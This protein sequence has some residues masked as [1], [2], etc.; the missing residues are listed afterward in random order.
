M[1][2]PSDKS[3]RKKSSGGPRRPGRPK[4]P[5]KREHTHPGG[6]G[7]LLGTQLARFSGM[8]GFS[9]LLTNVLHYGSIVVVAQMLGPGSLGAY[10]LLFFLTALVTQ[11]IHIALQAG[12]D[13]ADLRRLRRR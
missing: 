11:V 2:E 13:D 12:D 7:A 10:A 8:Q 5:E 3:R 1:T 6:A 9:L 4:A